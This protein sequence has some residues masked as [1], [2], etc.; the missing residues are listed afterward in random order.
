MKP[1]ELIGKTCYELVHGAKEPVPNCPHQK[2][3]KTKKPAIAEFLEPHLGIHLEVSSSPIF[4]EKG[5]V[6]ASV[7][8]AR[9]ITERK[10][11]EAEKRELE[12]R[13]QLVSRL[14]SVGEMASGIAHEINNPLT[15]VIGFSQLL[16]EGEI[17]DDIREDLGIICSEAQRAAEIVKNLLTFAR[18]RE[19][20]KQ[21]ANINSI[22]EGV[23]KLRDY[24]QRVSNIQ[25]IT[26]FDSTLPEVMVDYSQMQQVLLNIIINAEDAMLETHGKGTLTI[27][28]QKVNS[29]I[30]ASFTDDGP[31]MAKETLNRIFDPFLSL[32]LL[33]ILADF[34][35]LP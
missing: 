7:H 35:S 29:V 22:I 19:P 21:L 14:A 4:N 31:G 1:R 2:T 20:V 11:A 32:D 26:Q 13:A 23:L 16:M 33:N 8:I 28:T 18:K 9:D 10:Q 30:R 5:E 3:L 6:I 25:V 15:S 27:T 34:I 12:Q 24:E 17:S